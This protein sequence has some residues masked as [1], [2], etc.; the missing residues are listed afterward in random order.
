M[1]QQNKH[2]F[3][4]TYNYSLLGILQYLVSMYN[5]VRIDISNN[6]ISK[7]SIVHDEILRRKT[8]SMWSEQLV[9]LNWIYTSNF[10]VDLRNN[11]S[12]KCAPD[13]IW[14]CK[15]TLAALWEK[16]QEK[17]RY[18]QGN[19]RISNLNGHFPII[20]LGFYLNSS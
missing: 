5:M 12:F 1:I 20:F 14:T 18:R 4:L 2:A 7:D 19:R 13:R 9:W 17:R 11:K 10:N 8:H 6:K 15:M 16:I 3:I